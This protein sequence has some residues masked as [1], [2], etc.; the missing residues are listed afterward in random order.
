MLS[1]THPDAEK[2]QIELIRKGTER[3]SLLRRRALPRGW[4][5]C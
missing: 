5:P 3:P 4:P 2:V 1:D